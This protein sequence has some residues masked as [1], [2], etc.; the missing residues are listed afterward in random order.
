MA[1]LLGLLE[2]EEFVGR[3]W[4]RLVGGEEGGGFP[5]A[6]VQLEEVRRT[7]AI[8]FRGLGGPS[9]LKLA[10]LRRGEAG[11]R[12][13]WRE[14]LAGGARVAVARRDAEAVR[15]PAVIDVLPDTADNRALYL[16]LAALLAHLPARPPQPPGVLRDVR[17]L[18]DV[19][20]ATAA[21]LR[22]APGLA[23]V[24]A[25]LS[26]AVLR[27]RPARRLPPAEAAVEA[28]VRCLLDG[29]AA[30]GFA[31]AC[32][33]A[34]GVP[35]PRGYRGFRPV[36]LWGEAID[37]PPAALPPAADDSVSGGR[38]A[39]GDQRTHKARRQEQEQTGR[40]D[41]LALNR[42]E[43]M[44]SMTES[45]NLARPVEDDDEQGARRAADDA[46]E[47]VLSQHGR[48]AAT[49]LRLE[50]DLAPPA[51][52]GEAA[53]AGLRYPEWDWR[54]RIYRPAYCRVLAGPA[55]AADEAMPLTPAARRRIRHVRRQ[56]AALLPTRQTLRAQPDGE[57]LDLEALVRAEADRRAGSTPAERLHMTTRPATR[58]LAVALLVDVSLSTDS[59]A[60]TQR[61]IDTAR[62]AALVFCHALDASGDASAVFT[63]TS[64]GRQAVTVRSVKGFDETLSPTV[65]RRLGG[66]QPGHYT[67][68]GAALRH[69]AAVLQRQPA[70]Q[71][72][73]LLLTDGK[74]N[75]VDHYAGRFGI[76]DTSRAVKEARRAGTL[77]FAIAI[78]ATAAMLP[79]LF[80]HG[81]F[82]VAANPARLPLSIR[83]LLRHVMTT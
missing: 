36:P 28:A 16:W 51:A 57:E 17:F 80:G 32:A 65:L 30:A 24:H 33:Q 21:T 18:R 56:F 14:R 5:A 71:H 15:L 49:R 39:E 44:L 68:I 25:R 22:S 47:I 37:T 2:P 8:L 42:F 79:T 64:R 4:H 19:A 38:S 1:F 10:A 27:L 29:G 23:P 75:D 52:D 67:R 7:L 46:D 50:L 12:L 72:L 73:L 11:H 63:F 82:A 61:V 77:V 74:P 48:R 40:R 55:P 54:R 26:A 34:L 59:A 6:A 41:W 45:M 62:E 3:R 60:G 83:A 43:K 9:A 76:E 70:R 53:A 78:D 13:S 20:A 81:G 35:A 58:D 31:A 66:M 69:V